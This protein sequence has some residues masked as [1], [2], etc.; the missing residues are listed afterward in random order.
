MSDDNRYLMENHFATRRSNLSPWA[1]LGKV[2]AGKDSNQ[3][4]FQ[5]LSGFINGGA[6]CNALVECIK[7][8]PLSYNYQDLKE[9]FTSQTILLYTNNSSFVP[10]VVSS[11]LVSS[12]CRFCY[13]NVL[14]YHL[15]TYKL[16]LGPDDFTRARGGARSNIVH[17]NC[18]CFLQDLI[19]KS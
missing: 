4:R 9:Y 17:S 14:L 2:F 12:A 1:L 11:R 15:I 3:N 13:E 18:V 6:T 19:K 10:T 7:R 5:T 16:G 8:L